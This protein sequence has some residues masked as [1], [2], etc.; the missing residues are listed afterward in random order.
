VE[1][2]EQSIS[3]LK[4]ISHVF[5]DGSHDSTPETQAAASQEN[6]S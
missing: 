3:W 4:K 6:A 5:P 1:N 2:N